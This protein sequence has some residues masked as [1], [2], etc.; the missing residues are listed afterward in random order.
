MKDFFRDFTISQYKELLISLKNS[1]YRSITSYEYAENDEYQMDGKVVILRHDVDKQSRSV[2][3]LALLENECNFS[4]IYYFRKMAQG[5][6]T[7]TIEAIKDLKH[8]IGYHYE[9][10]SKAKGEYEQAYKIFKEEL[11]ELR[12]IVDVNTICMHGSPFFKWDNRDLWKKYDYRDLNIQF[13]P[14]CDLDFNRFLYLTDTGR[15]WNGGGVNL[16]DKV[17]SAFDFKLKTTS[18]IIG[19]LQN[20]ELPDRL[21][22]NCHPH[23][24]HNSVLPWL[25][26]LVWQNFKNIFKKAKIKS[27][28]K[29]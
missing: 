14:Y 13:E 8:D 1:G 11:A 23:R 27:S 29:K 5:F 2:L 19:A 9:A 17:T 16:R 26:E 21:I 20:N 25:K 22:I 15:T 12:N 10:L 24:W 3:E 28:R 6:D 7:R 4:A 18:D